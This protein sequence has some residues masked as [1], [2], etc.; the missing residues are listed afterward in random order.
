[1]GVSIIQA[2]RVLALW[3]CWTWF[4]AACFACPTLQRG[5]FPKP[6][7]LQMKALPILHYQDALDAPFHPAHL[8][9]LKDPFPLGSRRGT[10]HI[11]ADI[12]R[13]TVCDVLCHCPLV[14]FCFCLFEHIEHIIVCKS[15]YLCIFV[16]FCSHS[17]CNVH[18]PISDAVPCAATGELPGLPRDGRSHAAHYHDG[19]CHGTGWRYDGPE[20]RH[21]GRHDDA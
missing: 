3:Y 7:M 17:D 20:Y 13:S 6:Q 14:C 21:D 15:S 9:C 12:D 5:H 4:K 19:G 11:S 8:F 18:G 10:A 16:R 1:M 2:L